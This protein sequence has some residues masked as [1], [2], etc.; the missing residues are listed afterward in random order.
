LL[1]DAKGGGET[2]IYLSSMKLG[3]LCIWIWN[4]GL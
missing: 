3:L 1:L 2:F 4:N